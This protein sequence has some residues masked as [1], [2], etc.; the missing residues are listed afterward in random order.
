VE[1]REALYRPD[2]P[3][4]KWIACAQQT[5]HEALVW[6]PKCWRARVILGAIYCSRFQWEDAK[7]EFGMARRIAPLETEEHFYYGAYLAATGK[8][9]EAVKLAE[10]R[11]RRRREDLLAGLAPAALSY[12][13]RQTAFHEAYEH[14]WAA[15]RENRSGWIGYALL[16]CITIGVAHAAGLLGSTAED[17]IKDAHERLGLE[18]FPGLA[19]LC[20]ARR[21]DD[22]KDAPGAARERRARLH[23]SIARLEIAARESYV[24]PVQLALAHMAVDEMDEAVADLRRACDEGDPKMAWLHLWPLFD[25]LRGHEGFKALLQRLIPA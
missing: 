13:T 19:I 22:G 8:S 23:Q 3:P 18:A 17:H 6:D 11:W 21:W 16:A 20:H 7:A 10:A 4:G 14:A 24:P 12:L 5:A 9:E 25:P 2:A 1:F 15:I